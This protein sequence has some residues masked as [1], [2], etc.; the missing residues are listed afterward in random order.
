MLPLRKPFAVEHRIELGLLST[1]LIFLGFWLHHWQLQ[2]AGLLVFLLGALESYTSGWRYIQKVW[3]VQNDW[4]T[5][6]E[7]A[8]ASP[9]EERA[10]ETLRTW[11][12]AIARLE[13][14][15]PDRRLADPHLALIQS[16]RTEFI[17]ISEGHAAERA[18]DDRA[19]TAAALKFDA[20]RAVTRDVTEGMNAPFVHP[21]S[22]DEAGK[23]H[24]PLTDE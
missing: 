14:I 8:K 5:G 11:S 16:L 9:H 19:V 24:R 12:E 18:G 2:L 15:G 10:A 17:A 13:A 4:M 20:A 21:R 23:Q 3:A 6:A 1:A 7:K 22:D